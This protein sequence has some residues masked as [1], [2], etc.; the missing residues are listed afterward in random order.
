MPSIRYDIKQGSE[1][2]LDLRRTKITATD[3]CAIMGAS[4]WKKRAQLLEEKTYPKT[5]DV[6]NKYMERGLELEEPAR[7]LFSIKTGIVVNPAVV[8]DNINP[9]MMA[10]LDG[11]SPCGKYVVEIKCP[12]KKDHNKCISGS[13]PDKYYPQIQHQMFVCGVDKMFYFSFDGFDGE[14]LEVERSEIYIEQLLKEESK[15]FEEMISLKIAMG[16]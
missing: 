8:F 1:E 16:F 10:S 6:K 7:Q 15:F 11:I 9:W 13:I 12:G 14:I 3:A 2:W 5:C 4:P